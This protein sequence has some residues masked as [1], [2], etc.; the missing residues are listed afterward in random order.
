M[1]PFNVGG[2]SAAFSGSAAYTKF[3]EHLYAN[4]RLANSGP[5]G[6]GA[7]VGNEPSEEI[8]WE[9]DYTGAPEQAQGAIRSVITNDYTPTPGGLPGNDDGG[10]LSSW[11]VWAAIG[12]YPETPGVGILALGSPLF[13]YTEITLGNG[14]VL[15]L[16]ANGNADRTPYI[17]KM[18]V[19]GVSWNRAYLP[20]SAINGGGT[21]GYSLNSTP[22]TSWARGPGAAPPS[23]SSGETPA[24]GYTT[25]TSQAEVRSGGAINVH[26]AARN[27]TNSA[28]VVSWTASAASGIRLSVRSGRFQVP[29]SGDGQQ[30]VQVLAGSTPGVY[31]VTFHLTGAD[32]IALPDVVLNVV[33]A[34]S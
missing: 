15:T 11:Y 34:R 2:L 4:P 23:F 29:A 6:T 33:V 19:N 32:G 22:D 18:T 20:L 21:I 31:S 16:I 25:P 14:K 17:H 9:L 30:Q 7:F 3:L 27:I 24:I 5:H 28:Q 13:P 12:M 10:A 1:V 8:P 26:V